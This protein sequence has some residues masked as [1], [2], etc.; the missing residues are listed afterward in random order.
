MTC[1]GY[2]TKIDVEFAYRRH[3]LHSQLHSARINLAMQL[4]SDICE[5]SVRKNVFMKERTD[6]LDTKQIAD[7]SIKNILPNSQDVD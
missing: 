6:E 5:H 1:C 2:C 7:K 4:K 3:A